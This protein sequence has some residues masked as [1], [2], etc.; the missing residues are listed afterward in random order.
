MFNKKELIIVNSIEEEARI[1]GILRNNGIQ[2]ISDYPE[3]FSFQPERS[4]IPRSGEYHNCIFYV[5]K[6]DYERAL[7]IL[8]ENK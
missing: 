4:R 3:R 6:K 1:R 5:K 2:V 7:R 8:H